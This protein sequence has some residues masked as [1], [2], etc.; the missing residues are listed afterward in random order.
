MLS[1]SA[2]RPSINLLSNAN[3]Y[4]SNEYSSK[5]CQYT[6][7]L[8]LSMV[9]GYWNSQRFYGDENLSEYISY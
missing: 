1:H 3:N 7:S 6:Y 2:I 9:Y 5:Y 8:H 4:R